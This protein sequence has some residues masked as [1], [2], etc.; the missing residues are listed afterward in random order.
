MLAR[1]EN[2]LLESKSREAADAIKIAKGIEPA[3]PRIAFLESQ[4]ARELDRSAAAQQE[5]AKADALNQKLAGLIRL[6]NE[7]LAQDRL[8]EPAN[9]SARS[10]FL[11]A[12]ELDAGSVLV[13]QGLRSLADELVQKGQQAAVRGDNEAADQWIAQARQLNVSGIDFG[14]IERDA[15]SA[16]RSKPAE[17]DRLLGLARTRLTEGALLD[18]ENDSARFY[19]GQLRQQYP[20][21]AGLAPIVDSL[22]N[23]LVDQ[24]SD[25]VIRNDVRAGQRYLDEAQGAGRLGRGRSSRWAPRLTSRG[26]SSSR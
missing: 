25:A 23:Q 5:A 4:V 14:K 9:D 6:G 12:R 15:K 20:D 3:H 18:P 8:V 22:R 10:Y 26:A 21:K 2:A 19:V 16:Q 11:Q 7:R 13:L 24:A 1:A 17:G